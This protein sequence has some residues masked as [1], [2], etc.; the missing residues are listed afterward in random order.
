M[1]VCSG[2]VGTCV[3]AAVS[4]LLSVLWGLKIEVISCVYLEVYWG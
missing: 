4:V 1:L 2:V 3:T